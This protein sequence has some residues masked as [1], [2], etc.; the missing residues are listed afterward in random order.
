MSDSGQAEIL[1]FRRT[2]RRTDSAR[3]RHG[4]RRKVMSQLSRRSTKPVIRPA[5]SR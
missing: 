5:L 1:P 4:M 2:H 3:A